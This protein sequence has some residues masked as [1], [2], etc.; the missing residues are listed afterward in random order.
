VKRHVV[1]LLGPSREAISGVTT[2]LNGLL[3]SRLASRFDLVHFQVGSEGRREGFLGRAARLALSPLALAAAI[4][5]HGAGL[6]HINT[7]LNAKAYWRDFAYVVAAKL[8][9]ARVLY[10]VHGGVWERFAQKGGMFAAL[11]RRMLRWPDAV[12]VLSRAQLDALRAAVPEQSVELV[13]NG[14]DCGPYLRYNRPA[15]EPQAPLRLI[16]IGRL[17]PGKGLLETIEGLRLARTRGIS[18]RLVIAGN[19]PALSAADPVTELGAITT[20]PASNE[21]TP[22]LSAFMAIKVG[23][24]T[25]NLGLRRAKAHTNTINNK[26]NLQK[27][28]SHRPIDVM[29]GVRGDRTQDLPGQNIAA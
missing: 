25:G 27:Y 22:P 15:P 1:L 16:Y 21:D 18:A 7:S 29:Q 24:P 14:I 28:R 12:V 20:L 3:G 11:L 13:P 19:G 26:L 5:R 10:Q 17:V 2:H 6:V 9:G 4:A 23:V 8:C